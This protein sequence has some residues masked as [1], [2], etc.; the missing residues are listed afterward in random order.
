MALERRMKLIGTQQLQ[1]KCSAR[2]EGDM[3]EKYKSVR[4]TF[5]CTRFPHVRQKRGMGSM[6]IAFNTSN[7]SYPH[8]FGLSAS[9]SLLDEQR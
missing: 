8:V 5:L 1:E 7:L 3:F 6:M 4:E 2:I 9:S